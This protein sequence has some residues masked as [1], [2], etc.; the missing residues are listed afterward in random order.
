MKTQRT[1]KTNT[2]NATLLLADD[3]ALVLA[4]L[5]LGLK[6]AGFTVI[7]AKTGEEA[8]DLAQ[9]GNIDLALL[10]ISMPGLSGIETAKVLQ[11]SYQIPFLFLSAYND[12]KYVSD[13]IEQGALGYLVKP[14][15]V[16]QMIPTIETALTRAADIQS[17][18]SHQDNLNHA[19]SQSRETS[20]AIGIFMSHSGLSPDEAESALR[21]YCR[22]TQQKMSQVAKSIIKAS[23]DLNTLINAINSNA[24]NKNKSK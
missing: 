5:S 8:I 6:A 16:N 10:D 1:T 22:N 24:K 9:S 12:E 23:E 7:E 2:H 21:L 15:D 19:L 4:T 18:M 20:V 14:I 17:L 3:N 11:N 13:A